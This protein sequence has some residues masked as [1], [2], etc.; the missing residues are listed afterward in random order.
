MFAPLVIQATEFLPWLG[1][2]RLPII[3][4]MA[5]LQW[6]SSVDTGDGTYHNHGFNQFYGVRASVAKDAHSL[7]VEGTLSRTNQHTL[8]ADNGRITYRRRLAND[9]VGDPLSVVAGITLTG[10]TGRAL[11]DFNTIY[12]GK[13][14]V[15]LH[16]AMGK[17]CACRQFWMTR[18]WGAVIV[19]KSDKGHAWLRTKGALEGNVCDMHQWRLFLDSDVGF[20]HRDLFVNPLFDGYQEIRYRLVDVGA[21]YS[22]LM[23]RCGRAISLEYAQRL[24]SKNTLNNTH[25]LTVKLVWPF[26]L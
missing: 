14:E 24:Y 11:R 22:F 23:D 7:E 4:P 19:G 8:T 3:T 2:D 16:A 9:V 10:P 17:E 12:H 5:M 20:G 26:N 21:A 1:P 6:Y 18:W 13:I 15:E 25:T